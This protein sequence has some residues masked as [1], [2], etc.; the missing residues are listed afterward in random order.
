MLRPAEAR[1]EWC[2][3]WIVPTESRAND[4]CDS[5]RRFLKAWTEFAEN[6]AETVAPEATYQAWF[7]H[8]LIDQF[9][10]LRVVREVDFGARHLAPDDRLTFAGVNLRLDVCVLRRAFVYLPHRSALGT[11]STAEGNAARSGLLRLADL[12][13]VSELKVASTVTKR[14]PYS[15]VVRDARKLQA[16]LDAGRLLP[17]NQHSTMPLAYLCVLDNHPTW[18]FN[19]RLLRQEMNKAGPLPD[20]RLVVH[21]PVPEH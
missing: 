4:T 2:H 20:V 9:G 12:D 6:C 13:I 19:R 16:I 8:F 10:L 5:H 1:F 17:G 7:A 18:R 11:R 15:A 3:P 21:P 14:L